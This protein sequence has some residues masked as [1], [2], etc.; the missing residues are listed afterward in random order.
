MVKF[1]MFSYQ[2]LILEMFVDMLRL[3]FAAMI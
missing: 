2:I 3:K 1:K